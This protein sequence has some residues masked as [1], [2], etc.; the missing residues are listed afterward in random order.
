MP[1][2]PNLPQKYEESFHPHRVPTP[3]Q[4]VEYSFDGRRWSP[5]H[6]EEVPDFL[7]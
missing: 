2:A 5:Y 1:P 3:F 7:R 6:D 4:K